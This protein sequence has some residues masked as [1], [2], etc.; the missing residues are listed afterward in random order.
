LNKN[1]FG[2]GFVLTGEER[3]IIKYIDGLFKSL[4]VCYKLHNLK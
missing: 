4:D 1:L 3:K 2:S